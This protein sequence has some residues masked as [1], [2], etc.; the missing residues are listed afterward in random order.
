MSPK[1]FAQGA[2][3]AGTPVTGN[4]CYFVA[5]NGSD[6]NNGLTESTPFEHAPGMP[7]CS[8]AC[9]TAQNKLGSAGTADPGIGLIF[10]GGDTWHEGNSNLAPYSGGTF[11]IIWSG[12]SSAC[13]Y[14]GPQTS[15]FYVGVDTTWFNSAS[16]GSSWCRPV[17]SGDNPTSTTPVSSCAYQTPSTNLHKLSNS[18]F[19]ASNND[20]S[21]L[22]FD[23]FEM[24]GF[25]AQ[26]TSPP[27]GDQSYIVDEGTGSTPGLMLYNNIYMHGW[28]ITTGTKANSAI[29]CILLGGGNTNLAAISQLVIDGADSVPGAC[30]WGQFPSFYHFKDS[31]VRYTTF[32]VGQNCHDI[33]DVILEYFYPETYGESTGSGSWTSHQNVLECNADY[34]GSTPNVLYNVIMRHDNAGMANAGF[35]HLQ[36]APSSTAA[37]YY[38]N[39]V[40]YDLTGGQYWDICETPHGGCNNTGA[41]GQY[42]F[43]NTFVDIIQPCYLGGPS[44]SAGAQYLSIANEHLI[45]T[46]LDGASGTPCNGYNSTSNVV[47]TDATAT[48]QGYTTGSR[49]PSGATNNCANDSTTPCGPTGS[50]VKTVA[51]GVNVQ[52]YCSQLASYTAE[53]AIG[54]DAANACKY[55]TTDGC[56]YNTS[57]HTMVCPGQGVVTRP[58]STAW[59]SGAYQYYGAQAPTNLTGTVPQQ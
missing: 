36:T 39:N 4:H 14:E 59:D 46:P 30:A 7:N 43:N 45:N 23:G 18:L 51:A 52:S 22:Y 9:L 37:E 32:G 31:I 35:E 3:P 6:S 16:C 27:G 55:G 42:M 21:Y 15:C 26:S 19:V 17:L 56:S 49:G 57:T 44:I 29:P 13:S 12:N 24:T 47:M 11:D 38:F 53:R 50:G 34:S 1:S 40:F 8:G 54:V 20:N 28:T 58:N 5:A 41:G 48:S 33:H 2:C 25:C 10:R